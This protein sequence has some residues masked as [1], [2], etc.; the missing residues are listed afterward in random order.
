MYGN[1]FFNPYSYQTP[2][3]TTNIVSN[4]TRN[5][6]GIAS[7]LA[8]SNTLANAGLNSI[9]K[10]SSLG[11]GNLLG[12]FSFTGFLNGAS[13]TLNIINQAIPVFYQIKPIINNA[14][15]MFRVMNAVKEDKPKNKI[16]TQRILPNNKT[17]IPS[18]NSID[19]NKIKNDF[20][21]EN[22]TFFI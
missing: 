4:L 12:K 6:T 19:N 3:Q 16:S 1:N 2:Y 13:K 17:T 10:T 8:R 20:K 21:E 7:G 15:T 14:K 5:G 11:L 22:P 18:T 9:G